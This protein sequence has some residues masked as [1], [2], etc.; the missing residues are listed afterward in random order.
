[1]ISDKKL[2]E[3]IL[4]ELQ[5]TNRTGEIE[6]PQFN[7]GFHD[8]VEQ[9]LHHIEEMALEEKAKRNVRKFINKK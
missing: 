9:I 7:N 4:N 8:C 3:W 5:P 2:A 1:M 6:M